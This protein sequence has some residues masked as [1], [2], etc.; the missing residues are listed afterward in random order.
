M[1]R[2]FNTAGPCRLDKHYMIPPLGRLPE[3]PGLVAREGYFVVHA[4]RQTGKTTAI[5]AL[6]DEL[7][8]SGRYAAL[9]FTCETARAAG[10]DYVRAQR[11]ILGQIRRRARRTLPPELRPPPW[12]E[13][14]EENLLGD[15]LAE[16]AHACP[17]PLVLFLDEIDALEDAPLISVLSQ[18]RAGY[19]ERPDGFPA[20]V[21]LCGMRDLRDYR[22]ASGGDPDRLRSGSPFNIKLKSLRI[23]D[24]TAGEVAELYAQQHPG[25]RFAMPWDPAPPR[26][27][28]SSRRARW[29]GRWS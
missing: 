1:V 16:W 29:R 28:R 18:L 7:T 27:A 17:R 11:G 5:R 10:D 8:A 23:G 14:D 9:A 22:A 13:A 3:A 4:P 20:S 24:F 2:A 12:P 25:H 6:A 26:P 21:V 15:G 19:D